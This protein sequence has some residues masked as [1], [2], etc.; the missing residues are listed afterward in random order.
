[1]FVD[2]LDRILD[3][4]D[5]ILRMLVAMADHRRQGG[6]FARAGR[7]DDDHQTARHHR[8]VFQSGWQMQLFQLRDGGVDVAHHDTGASLLHEHID[9]ESAD[10]GF[11]NGKVGFVS[12]GKFGLHFLV[13]QHFGERSA[14]AAG[15][16]LLADRAD[17]A[18]Q[19]DR[20]RETGSE[21]KVGRI[22]HNHETQP[23]VDLGQMIHGIGSDLG[24]IHG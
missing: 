22:A 8:D 16:R 20:R 7:A 9:P 23:F 24:A 4:D 21:K 3:R 11:E 18:I 2:E 6:R 19:F 10:F 13:H 1:M 15:Q 12:L 5:V 17:L 14:V